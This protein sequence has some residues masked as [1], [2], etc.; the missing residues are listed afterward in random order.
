[1]GPTL[2]SLEAG[3]DNQD[4]VSDTQGYQQ[5]KT[6]QY[7]TKNEGQQDIKTDRDLKIE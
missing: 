5:D 7:K 4:N 6:D 1:M 2:V 3:N